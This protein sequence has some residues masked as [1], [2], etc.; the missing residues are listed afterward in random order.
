MSS[1]MSPWAQWHRQTI[2]S[3][4]FVT[5]FMLF[6]FLAAGALGGAPQLITVVLSAATG[7]ALLIAFWA[8]YSLIYPE[9][10]I[11]ARNIPYFGYDKR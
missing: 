6:A 3:A 2:R 1:R 10:N 5:V 7:V 9:S 11:S 4:L 8:I